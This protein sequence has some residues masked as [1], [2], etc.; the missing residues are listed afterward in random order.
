MNQNYNKANIK[1]GVIIA[2]NNP[3]KQ[4]NINGTRATDKVYMTYDGDDIVLET[5]S[6]FCFR[7]NVDKRFT[8][9]AAVK[10]ATEH[11]YS[12]LKSL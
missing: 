7:F 5:E 10:A 9:S 1:A 8:R 11:F 3:K 2:F 6:G 12:L 4:L